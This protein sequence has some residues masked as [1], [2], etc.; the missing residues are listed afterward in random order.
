MII[1][2]EY[3]NA[4]Y[5]DHNVSSKAGVLGTQMPMDLDKRQRRVTTCPAVE[6]R[7]VP[8]LRIDCRLGSHL[9]RRGTQKLT[10]NIEHMQG[11]ASRSRLTIGRTDSLDISSQDAG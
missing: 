10:W 4:W 11:N 8:S 6:Q 7:E 9:S 1:D 3:S 2:K 5:F